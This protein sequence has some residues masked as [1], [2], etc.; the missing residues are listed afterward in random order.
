VFGHLNLEPPHQMDGFDRVIGLQI[1]EVS[2]ELARGTVPVRERLK[3]RAGLVDVGVYASIA[4]GLATTGTAVAVL[5]EG[6]RA[7]PLSSQT[8]FLRP[9]T[10]GTIHALAT[11]KH[12][13]RTTWVWDVEMCDDEHRPCVRTR[14]TLAVSEG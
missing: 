8:S 6:K 10:R 3:D 12:R 11:R 2:D 9:I 5:Q 13:G 7:L 1:T 4:E 14:M